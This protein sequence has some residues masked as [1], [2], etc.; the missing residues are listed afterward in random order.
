MGAGGANQGKD[1]RGVLH[2]VWIDIL[3]RSL[4]G[5]KPDELETS[6]P[7]PSRFLYPIFDTPAQEQVPEETQPRQNPG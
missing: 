5:I 2:G 7:G 6:E 3:L 1:E 4:K